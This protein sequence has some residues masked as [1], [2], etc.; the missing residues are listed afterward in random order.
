VG[1]VWAVWSGV[2]GER[3]GGG[4]LGWWRRGKEKD[5]RLFQGLQ[6]E[7]NYHRRL[8]GCGT[9]FGVRLTVTI[10]TGWIN[11]TSLIYTAAHSISQIQSPC[12][13]RYYVA[14]SP[15][16]LVRRPE[17]APHRQDAL[18]A[19][20][21]SVARLRSNYLSGPRPWYLHQQ[22]QRQQQCLLPD[23]YHNGLPA[24]LSLHSS[25]VR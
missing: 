11:S 9:F 5:T 25:P 22:R 7:R 24:Y 1:G 17:H 4:E 13:L 2:G 18:T 16:K 21:L 12:L 23:T 3:E 19:R 6:S 20:V 15:L 10:S 8:D 14:S